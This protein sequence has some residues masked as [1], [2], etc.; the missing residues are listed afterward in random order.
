MHLLGRHS[1]RFPRSRSARQLYSRFKHPTGQTFETIGKLGDT[2]QSR[3]SWVS[4]WLNTSIKTIIS[5]QPKG[6][7]L[8]EH[9]NLLNSLSL[10]AC[11]IYKDV[12]LSQGG[13]SSVGFIIYLPTT[14]QIKCYSFNLGTRMDITDKE[15]YCV[16]KAIQTAKKLHI[17]GDIIT[18][19]D[20][21]ASLI[22]TQHKPCRICHKMQPSAKQ[23]SPGLN[24]CLYTRK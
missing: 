18:F 3:Q 22:Q 8:S 1:R 7:A 11:L 4:T 23:L 10:E 24:L 19:S 6:V 13:S 5:Q 20:S 9:L 17:S 14:R 16:L 2:E 21:Q 12:S 15:A